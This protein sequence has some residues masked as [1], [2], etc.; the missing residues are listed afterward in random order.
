M[1]SPEAVE[2]LG[3]ME[4]F[5]NLFLSGFKPATLRVVT[6]VLYFTLRS[7]KRLSTVCLY[8]Y[9]FLYLNPLISYILCSRRAI[10][11]LS[12]DRLVQYNHQ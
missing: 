6:V 3:E 11:L 10:T 12:Y 8:I 9:I 1:F 2:I 4:Y 5:S 7:Y